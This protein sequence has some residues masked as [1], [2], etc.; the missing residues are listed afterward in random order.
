MNRLENHPGEVRALPRL[1]VKR[2][3]ELRQRPGWLVRLV[4][5][6]ILQRHREQQDEEPADGARREKHRE[7]VAREQFDQEGGTDRRDGHTNAQDPGNQA[8][9]ADWDLVR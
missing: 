4:E 8:T 1:D 6:A 9:L 2:A 5:P 7:L 3:D